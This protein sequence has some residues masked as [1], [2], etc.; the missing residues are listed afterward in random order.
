MMANYKKYQIFFCARTKKYA[1]ELQ[2]LLKILIQDPN[3]KAADIREC[4][5]LAH[6]LNGSAGLMGC[7]G[8]AQQAEAMEIFF[9]DTNVTTVKIN[10]QTLKKMEFLCHK[11]SLASDDFEKLKNADFD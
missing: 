1:V 6:I 11:I 5:R 8:L 4:Q 9:C 3:P 10:H 7:V 2:K